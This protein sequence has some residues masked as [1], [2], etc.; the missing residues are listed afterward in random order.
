MVHRLALLVGAI[1]AA[2]VLAAA[3]GFAGLLST[4]PTP[5]TDS[6]AVNGANQLVADSPVK[7]VVDTVYVEPTPEAQV[8]HVTRP[9]RNNP[10]ANA[11]RTAN[12]PRAER[13]R[14]RDGGG[15]REGAD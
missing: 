2:A 15:E 13:D 5:A 6:Q 14:E 8:V 4:A 9:A 1:G 12:R 3:M 10:T 11:T 7:T